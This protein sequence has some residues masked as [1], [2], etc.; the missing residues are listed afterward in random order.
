MSLVITSNI[1]DEVD[2]DET[3]RIF[4]PFSYSNRL[5]DTMK[6]PPNSQIALQS[7]KIN[8]KEE[9]V[10]NEQNNIFGNY[11]GLPLDA[12]ASNI[13]SSTSV[14]FVG[15]LGSD[16]R[17]GNTSL[18]DGQRKTTTVAETA[19]F[20]E[21]ALK[22]RTY[23]PSLITKAV[24][25]TGTATL[26]QTPV[27]VNVAV[28]PKYTGK[29]WDGFQWQFTQQTANTK[30]TADFNLVDVSEGKT[31]AFDL[32][33]TNGAQAKAGPGFQVQARNQPISQNDGVTIFDF[34]NANTTAARS[35][36]FVSLSRISTEKESG[37]TAPDSYNPRRG[38]SNGFGLGL[39]NC[40][41]TMFGDIVVARV[42]EFLRVFQSG[43][44]SGGDDG[45]RTEL[46]LN[47]IEYYGQTSGG[48]NIN[49]NFPYADGHYNLRTNVASGANYEKVKFKLTN[50]HLQIFLIDNKAAEVLLVDNITN[51]SKGA[52]KNQLTNPTTC[53]KWALY[54]HFGARGSGHSI[55]ITEHNHYTSYPDFALPI[56]ENPAVYDWWIFSESTLNGTRWARVMEGR[57]FNDKDS[58]VVLTP[59]LLTGVDAM[60]GYEN[61]IIT[62][63]LRGQG[64][65]QPQRS[66]VF[67]LTQ[68]CNT[69]SVFGFK[70]TPVSTP[71][72]GAAL[73]ITIVSA[74]QP[75]VVSNVSLFVRLNNFT[76]LSTNARMGTRSKIVGHLPRFDNSGAETGALYFEPSEKTYIDINNSNELTINSFDVDLC[77]D[78]E[79]LATGLI[80]KTIVIFHIRQKPS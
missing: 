44:D 24:Q 33:G 80:G 28:T 9:I 49:S 61:Q 37:I 74:N 23:H 13:E 70:Y 6:I 67:F 68:P 17:R 54:P 48:A 10:L 14:P 39:G 36:W 8:K 25:G 15:A 46:V 1:E 50:E 27:G 7:A 35:S 18:A 51:A 56:S 65:G 2:V 22:E 29:V 43:T 53:A 55:T 41:G 19:L 66:M 12:T 40:G 69:E 30:K 58:D 71:E 38:G 20:I 47:E 79:R 45:S 21:D 31:N 32:V 78:N 57:P 3:S 62:A 42:G 72:A 75:T 60:D 4:K 59:K 34:T 63:P 11:F 16:L 5:L 26:P 77:F 52:V 73:L 76:Q 64:R